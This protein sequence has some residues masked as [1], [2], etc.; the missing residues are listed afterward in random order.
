MNGFKTISSIFDD[1]IYNLFGFPFE[2]I[3]NS[4]SAAN[5]SYQKKSIKVNGDTYVAISKDGEDVK[6]YKNGKKIKANEIPAKIYENLCL[7]NP[8]SV[9]PNFLIPE[10]CNNKLPEPI[11][12]GTEFPYCDVI[13]KEDKSLLLRFA[14]A[15]ISQDRVS[16]DFDEDYLTVKISEKIED[17][18]VKHAFLQRGIKGT[19]GE[20]YKNI[21]IDPKKYDIDSLKYEFKDGMLLITIQK[22]EKAPTKKV[23]L[24]AAKKPEEKSEDKIEE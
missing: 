11:V 24:E 17:E 3:F 22:S 20:Y 12:S 4:D 7:E 16:I 19:D 13:C 14:L 2:D 5:Y 6:C 18:N 1:A 8:V 15:G 23:F 10:G 9:N 21:F